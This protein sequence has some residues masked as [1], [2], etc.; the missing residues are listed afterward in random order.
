MRY[1]TGEEALI[2]FR[3]KARSLEKNDGPRDLVLRSPSEVS[4]LAFRLVRHTP[5]IE[6]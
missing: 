4:T 2:R 6:R 1:G 5:W 3:L